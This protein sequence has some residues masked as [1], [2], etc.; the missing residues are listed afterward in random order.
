MLW[1]GRI[2]GD[3]ASTLLGPSLT[4]SLLLSHPTLRLRGRLSLLLRLSSSRTRNRF[5]V[6]SRNCDGRSTARFV[7]QCARWLAG[8]LNR[9]SLRSDSIFG[10]CA[11]AEGG[12]GF[13][14]W[15]AAESRARGTERSGKGRS[16]C[17]AY[18]GLSTAY[19]HG[20]A[21]VE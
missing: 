21:G 19:A 20:L 15:S 14:V 18:Y 4:R 16:L 10:V 17:A 1:G 7:G 13:G 3:G 8:R 2:Q 11:L 5:G 6:V 9:R 12:K